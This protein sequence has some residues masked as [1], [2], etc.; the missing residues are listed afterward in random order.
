MPNPIQRLFAQMPLWGR[1]SITIFIAIATPT[2]VAFFF[3]ER[4]IRVTD[5]ENLQTY[6]AFQG[7]QRRDSANVFLTSTLLAMSD[8]AESESN[9]GFLIRLMA[10]N[11][12]VDEVRNNLIEQIETRLTSAGLFTQ[13]ELLNI[14]GE[15]L[16]SNTNFIRGQREFVVP[17]GTD[18]SGEAA[19]QTAINAQFTGRT[20]SLIATGTPDNPRIQVV[21]VVSNIEGVVGYIVGTINLTSGLLP[22]LASDA[23]FV[24]VFSYLTTSEGL[25]ITSNDYRAQAV[26]SAKVSPI[27]DAL[28]QD[29]GTQLY[30][31]GE[32]QYV[33]HYAPVDNTP[34]ALITEAPLQVSFVNNLVTLIQQFPVLI[35]ILLFVWGIL[36]FLTYVALARPLQELNQVVQAVNDGNYSVPISTLHRND[37]IGVLAR[38]IANTREQVQYLLNDLQQRIVARVRTTGAHG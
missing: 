2:I 21:Y 18:K 16:L 30:R 31:V 34:F 26:A 32:V 36:T 27:L 28:V 12:Q 1:L 13:V 6:I 35:L 11:S 37:D 22:R 5:V 17:L 9:R 24:A 15:V 4:E 29:T 38:T 20:I 33:G 8:F 3:I 14:D 25:V 10:F 7:N 23:G 19:Y